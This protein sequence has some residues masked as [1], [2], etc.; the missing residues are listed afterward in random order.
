[1]KVDLTPFPSYLAKQPEIDAAWQL[2]EHRLACLPAP[3]D[4]LGARFLRS[5]A[6][7]VVAHRAYFSIPIAPPLLYMPLWLSDTLGSRGE[8]PSN[9]EPTLPWILAGTIFGYFYIR[10]QD[11]TIDEP[12]RADPELL[13]FGN[14]CFTSM[15]VMYRDALEALAEPFFQAFDRAFLDFSRHTLAEQRA[16]RSADPYPTT[17]FEEHADKVAFARTPLLAVATLARRLDLEEPIAELVH[18]LG[19]AYGLAN[20]LLGW[21][22]DLRAGHRTHLL[23][24]AGLERRALDE[25]AALPDG[26]TKDAARDALAEQLRHALYEGGRLHDTARRAIE[27]HHHAAAAAQT[28]GLLGFEAFTSER[29]AWLEA[30]DRE[31]LTLTL[32]R[33]L[34]APR[35]V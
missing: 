18:R 33:V 11:D 3:L 24:E 17:L 4:E 7:S 15:V 8:L 5:I 12:A 34:A 22:R 28:L 6:D 35:S 1:V 30:L 2:C 21:P 14:T 9:A 27:A 31:V 16:V 13:L 26:P 32:R 19:I 29:V 10:I 25:I 23:A 20:D